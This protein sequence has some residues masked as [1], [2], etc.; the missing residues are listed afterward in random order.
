MSGTAV[1]MPMQRD[2][3]F[4]DLLVQCPLLHGLKASLG[5]DRVVVIAPHEF[6]RLAAEV[7]LADEVVV[8]DDR[9][10]DA[11]VRRL[12]EEDPRW[13]LSLRGTSFRPTHRIR[14]T[15]R[16]GHT[17]TAGFSEVRDWNGATRW[18]GFW[19]RVLLDVTVP[20]VRDDYF[21][22]VFG[23]LLEALGGEVDVRAT[24]RA[25]EQPHPD[26]ELADGRRRLVAVPAGK[27][28]EKQWGVA[29]Y[30]ALAERLTET[31]SN[32]VPTAVLG[33]READLAP[34]LEA[35]GWETRVALPPRRLA[36]LFAGAA[37]IVAND[38]GPGHLAHM[39]GAPMVT[40]FYNDG[41]PGRGQEI[42]LWW[43]RRPHSRALTTAAVR[44]IT[45]LPVG[46]VLDQTL[47]AMQDDTV[48]D[49]PLWW[50]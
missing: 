18:N 45:E 28:A 31:Y 8:I 10:D 5:A 37:C 9:D 38:C 22:L 13:A 47:K 23:R 49:E 6:V 30:V 4:G 41:H 12:R 2:S 24:G 17:T 46:V 50:S 40:L 11:V 29:N 15:R 36:A 39:S 35:A 16:A 43:W 42:K 44:P 14:R 34:E 21:A 3:S 32:L 25:I 48:I 20:Q 7:G 19:A 26:D 27:I 33:P 1:V